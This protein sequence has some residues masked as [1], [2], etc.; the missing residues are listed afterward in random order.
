MA[1]R[2]SPAPKLC[3][4]CQS[5]AG[6]KAGGILQALLCVD[7]ARKRMRASANEQLRSTAFKPY[8]PLVAPMR[9]L[10]GSNTT[11]THSGKLLNLCTS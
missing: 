11:N 10:N 8:W 7:G 6:R 4:V 3:D 9:D 5:L 2:G 1:I